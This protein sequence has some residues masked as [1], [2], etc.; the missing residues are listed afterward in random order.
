MRNCLVVVCFAC[1]LQQGCC[2]TMTKI[3]TIT[4]TIMMTMAMTLIIASRMS[5]TMMMTQHLMRF[6][7]RKQL[8]IRRL[9]LIVL[10]MSTPLPLSLSCSLFHSLL[11]VGELTNLWDVDWFA[12][13]DFSIFMQIVACFVVAVVAAVSLKFPTANLCAKYKWQYKT[14]SN[15]KLLE[16]SI[17]SNKL[18][19]FPSLSVFISLSLWNGLR[20][21]KSA[22]IYC[23]VQ[24]CAKNKKQKRNSVFKWFKDFIRVEKALEMFLICKLYNA[25]INSD[26]KGFSI[27]Q[28]ILFC[29]L[30][31]HS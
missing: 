21:A 22:A 17:K 25:K 9:S 18:L 4:I 3:M 26:C 10:A 15:F 5:K 19:R 28:T 29:L 31:K 2:H 11:T 12:V 30:L 27:C 1:S 16:N 24:G 7:F 20:L 8:I 14:K 23:Q 6:P 13:W